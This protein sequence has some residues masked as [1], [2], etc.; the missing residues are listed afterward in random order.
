MSKPRGW[1]DV[2]GAVR[3]CACG[4]VQEC[5]RCRQHESEVKRLRALCRDNLDSA[6][7]IIERENFVFDNLG[8]RWQK[9]AFTFYTTLVMMAEA[10]G[11]EGV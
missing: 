7:D 10:A 9:L 6:K 2:P 11:E 1:E 3:C 8:N 5:E 4:V